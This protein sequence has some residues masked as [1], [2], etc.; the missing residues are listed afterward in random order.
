MMRSL[1]GEPVRCR[2]THAAPTIS[3]ARITTRIYPPLFQITQR[4]SKTGMGHVRIAIK[5]PIWLPKQ[6]RQK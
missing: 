4:W 2:N 6:D 1:S 5:I 3:A